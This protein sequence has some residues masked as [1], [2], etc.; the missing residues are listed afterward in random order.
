M[1]EN[2]E[3]IWGKRVQFEIAGYGRKKPGLM[4]M[5]QEEIFLATC[6]ATLRDKL[7]ERFHV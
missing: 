6:L 4:A 7:Q 5:L 3:L 2:T 1:T